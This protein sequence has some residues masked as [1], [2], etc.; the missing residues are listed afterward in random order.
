MD[1]GIRI[2]IGLAPLLVAAGC[3]GGPSMEASRAGLGR[4]AIVL[5]QADQQFKP[6]YEAARVETRETSADWLERDAKLT[7]WEAAKTA[8][9]AL[10]SQLLAAESVLD[11]Q[12][13]GQQSDWLMVVGCA[14]DAISTLRA[15]WKEIG[16]RAPPAL[17]GAEAALRAVGAACG[18]R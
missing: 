2:L 8:L 3:A 10:K 4:A 6:V 9:V 14:A 16:Q 12:E 1:H 5:L 17:S 18:G 11:A 15:A 13:A 7:Y